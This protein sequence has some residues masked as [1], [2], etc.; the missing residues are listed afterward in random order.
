MSHRR[1]PSRRRRPRPRRGGG[2][3]SS[4]GSNPCGGGRPGSSSD[5]RLR[6]PR[7]GRRRRHGSGRQSPGRG[8]GRRVRTRPPR[9]PGTSSTQSNTAR[10][11]RPRNFSASVAPVN[12]PKCS[13]TRRVT[14]RSSAGTSFAARV[15]G[16]RL[17]PFLRRRRRRRRRSGVDGSGR[18]RGSPGR[19]GGRG[20]G[21]VWL[22]PGCNVVCLVPREFRPSGP[23]PTSPLPSW[24]A[25]TANS[26]AGSDLALLFASS[27]WSVVIPKS[28]HTCWIPTPSFPCCSPDSWIGPVA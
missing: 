1:L 15:R 23:G 18:G 17:P 25:T 28:G 5:A 7:S 12:F 14:R 24:G 13:H 27:V 16:V 19:G 9:G 26:T 8:P 4:G 6:S 10:S 2:S 3:P 22:V 21:G 20:L 11:S